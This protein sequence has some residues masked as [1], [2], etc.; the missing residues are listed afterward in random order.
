[1][2]STPAVLTCY[3][4][5]A[6][7][8]FTMAVG[9]SRLRAYSLAQQRMLIGLLGERGVRAEGGSDDRG[10]FI[11]VRSGRARAWAGELERRGVIVDSRGDILR[12]CPDLLSTQA[13]LARAAVLLGEIAAQ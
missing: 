12:L 3:Q 2:E 6:G 11:V 1:M 5:R 7:Q 9:V 8:L 13:E 10:A 4:A